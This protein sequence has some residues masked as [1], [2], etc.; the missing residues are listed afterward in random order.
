VTIDLQ[1]FLM[2]AAVMT[3]LAAP[4]Q[5]AETYRDLSAS[6]DARVED[7]LGRM[8][9][10]EKVAQ[11]RT[12]WDEKTKLFDAAGKFDPPKA[13]QVFPDGFGGFTRP[14]D[15][16][17]SA[18]PADRRA[19]RPVRD[20][21]AL[22]NAI[23]HWAIEDTRLGIPVLFHEEAL[24]G[25]MS[26]DATSFPQ[27]I[28]QASTWDPELVERIDA[29]VGREVRARGVLQVLSPV[30]DI[31]RDPRWG[32]TEETFGEDPY[33]VS[34]MSVAAVRGYQG[35]A[36]PLAKDRVFATLKH[37]TGHG[38]PENGI[39]VGPAN[40]GER[41][42]RTEFFP[43]FLA[44]I[45]QANAQLV[46]ASYNEIDGVP[47]H[48]NKWLLTD[49]LRGEWGFKG[50]VVSDYYGI[51]QLQSLHHVE[52]D[53]A[54]AAIR[55]L[56]SGVTMDLPDG[57]AFTTVPRSIA[58]R[59][60]TMDVIDRDVR[61]VLRVK[62]LAGL[63]E[64]PY[65]DPDAA[66]AV[67]NM[68]DAQALAT[69]AARKAVILLKNDG[70]LPLNKNR[71]KTLAVIGPNANVALLGGYSGTP[72]RT[73]NILQGI[74]A[75]LGSPVNV[76]YSEGVRITESINGHQNEV[77]LAD[78]Q[79]NAKRITEAVKVAREADE[80]VLVLGGNPQTSREGYATNHLG[81]RADI[82]LVGQQNDLF[83]AM[84]TLGKPVVVVLLNGRPLATPRIA[85][86]ANALI[87]GWYLGENGGTAM[88]DI[89]FG[90]ANPGGKLPITVPRS[91]DQLPQFYD[92]KPSARRGYLFS[93]V[94]P[95]FPFGFGLSYTS[96]EVGAPR[97]SSATIELG[98][99]VTVE[100]DLKNTGGR[101]GDEVVQLYVHD[102]VSSVTTRIKR[103]A[104]FERVTLKPGETKTV[105]FRLAPDSLALWNADMKYVVEPGQ[106]E[107]MAGDSSANLKSATLTVSGNAPVP[108]R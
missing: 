107:I 21:V 74:K 12:I 78:P 7:L 81:D 64:D 61:E 11:L 67:S 102:L 59:R 32:R 90:D 83:E 20:I 76:V 6:I 8:T 104:G 35:T 75:K 27:P 42:L 41:T 106:F 38:W 55:A 13:K 66:V 53:L 28:A 22:V 15:W 91:A 80:I 89:L 49:I 100:V 16:A 26:R 47:S 69:E 97:L 54:D 70:T 19:G 24:H 37:M 68:P 60:L 50:A 86:E 95:L 48:A 62:F 99:S 33:L 94:E 2:A 93:S 84:K 18:T 77:D 98:G 23:Q 65:A 29:V 58:D 9:L 43:P 44:A 10:D 46:M 56:D 85:E 17:G 40:I 36:L 101:E 31:V 79:E 96:F 71:I 1:R 45:R 52:P 14:T 88:A 72:K 82:G 108:V 87:E 105:R 4:A 39:N 73:V 30:V 3:L 103:L 34:R 25:Y 92:V 57:E 51:E 5:A 63:F